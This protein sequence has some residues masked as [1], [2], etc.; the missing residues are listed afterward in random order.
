MLHE[1]LLVVLET[2]VQLGLA[3]LPAA[4]LLGQKLPSIADEKRFSPNHPTIVGPEKPNF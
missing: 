3:I 2:S 1:W 4:P